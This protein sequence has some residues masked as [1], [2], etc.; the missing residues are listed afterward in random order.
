MFVRA[1]FQKFINRFPEN[2]ILL[3]ILKQF[4]HKDTIAEK[5]ILKGCSRHR[6][7]AVG[8]RGRLFAV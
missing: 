2:Q 1:L 4:W 5:E 3:Q 8:E 7:D 6:G